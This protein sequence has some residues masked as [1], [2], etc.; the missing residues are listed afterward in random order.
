[1]KYIKYLIL[2]I[3]PTIV[4]YL[5]WFYMND[6]PV[7]LVVMHGLTAIYV[8]FHAKYRFAPAWILPTSILLTPLAI[9]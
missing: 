5:A 9:Y 7:V 2:L 4:S 8:F 6:S 3:A 1:M